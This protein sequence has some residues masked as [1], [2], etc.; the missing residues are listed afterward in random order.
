MHIPL[1]VRATIATLRDVG[2]AAGS[3]LIATRLSARNLLAG[4]TDRYANK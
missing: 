4:D 1:S 2:I 3:L